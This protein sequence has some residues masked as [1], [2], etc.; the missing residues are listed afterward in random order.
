MVNIPGGSFTMGS[1]KDEA[2]RYDDEGP[3]H[4]VK[5]AT[6]FIGRFEITRQQWRQVAR[7]PPAKIELR[8]DPSHFND[9]WLQ[10]VEQVSWDEANEF[11]ERLR[12][13]TKKAYRLPTEA[14]WEYAA[15]GGTP[16]PFAFGETITSGIINYNGKHPYGFAPEGNYLGRTVAVGSLRFA[17]GFGIYD[18]LGNVSE[19]CADV[20]HQNYEGAPGNGS[21]WTDGGEQGN[22]VL[23]GGSRDSYGWDCRS[24]T[25]FK[26]EAGDRSLNVGFR[27]VLDGEQ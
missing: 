25:R 27:V 21:A 26:Y 2:Q 9:S 20:W 10:P 6:F 13:A 12:Q 1:P 22:R 24:A 3:Q 16:T 7:M 18:M 15:R 17:N 8:E 11:C 5:V 19:W 4:P 23:R 14:E